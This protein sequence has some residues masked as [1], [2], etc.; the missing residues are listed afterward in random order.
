MNVA[1][2]GLTATVAL[3]VLPFLPGAV[4][5][6]IPFRAQQTG[7]PTPV[8][9]TLTA[10]AGA[11]TQTSRSEP[12]R[13]DQDFAGLRSTTAQIGADW[14]EHVHI[15]PRAVVDF[16]NIITQQD[17]D[18]EIYSALRTQDTVVS[19]IANGATPGIELPNV[20]PPPRTI[21]AQTSLL[22]PTSTSN[23]AGTGLGTLVKTKVRA[24]TTGLPSFDAS[25][26]FDLTNG[27]DVSLLVKGSR[28]VL[29]PFPDGYES[30]TAE[31]LEF[32]TDVREFASGKEQR[33]SPRKQ[34][35]EFIDVLFRLTGNAKQRML[36]QILDW[37]PNAFGVPIWR[38]RVKLTAASSASATS[39]TV[40]GADEVDIRVGGLV[41][42]YSDANTF[43]VLTVATVSATTI[44]TTSGAVN[45]YAAG[46]VLMPVRVAYLAGKPRGT[47]H[48]KNLEEFRML[49]QVDDNDTG[50]LAGS[51]SGWSTYNG[52]VL[53]DE[54]N[55]AASQ[56]TEQSFDQRI[57]V[58]DGR[59]G[60]ISQSSV[61]AKSKG[62]FPLGF[63]AA[64]RAE[65]LSLKKLLRAIRGRQVAFY[66]RTFRDDIEVKASLASGTA[67]MDIERI[68][69]GRYVRVREPMKRLRVSFT[70]GTHLDRVVQ[71]VADVDATT[72]RL[73]LTTTWPTT[74]TVAE[75]ERV[76]FY[77]L[78]RFDV[79]SFR[80]DFDT[81]AQAR[82]FAPV[83]H[84]FDDD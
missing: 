1:H 26:V 74:R 24:L 48:I 25:I 9:L 56:T 81:M 51:T 65:I 31:I 43:D 45:A 42:L 38:D 7:L 6:Y 70:D 27:N 75:I 39:F 35:R 15:I 47:R 18:Y 63:R 60:R 16:G 12:A 61:W 10:L 13:N 82:L 41:A 14:Y 58:I 52:R 71:S 29:L 54:C 20:D 66:V 21:E 80:L 34:P 84:A 49:F 11:V 57:Y 53:I 83:R 44:T 72:E 59:T 2:A 64:N 68:E 69:Y 40:S 23:D 50:A 67:T 37:L 62:I 3:D 36:T 8:M 30:P 76:E 5:G 55:L 73:T 79:D 22:D 4:R 78:V 19:S 17:Q 77:Q 46:T 32:L 28:I 33:S